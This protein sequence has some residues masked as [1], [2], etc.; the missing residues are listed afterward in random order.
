[1]GV[2]NVAANLLFIPNVW[3]AM[4]PVC[5]FAFGWALMVPAVTILV[6]DLH[7][8][9]RGMASSLQMFVGTSANA[10]VAGLVS[11]LVMH[12]P[13]ALAVASLGLMSIGLVSWV[14]LHHRWPEIGQA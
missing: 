2:L 12:S 11:P 14:Y 7:P 5:I 13:V 9:R 8:D 10:I 3:W 6:L 4:L 1:V